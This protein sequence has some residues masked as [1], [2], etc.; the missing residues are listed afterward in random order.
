M[1]HVLAIYEVDRAWGGAE[2]G[3]W[4]APLRR[5]KGVRLMT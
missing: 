5:E 3:G 1:A 4:C 2:E